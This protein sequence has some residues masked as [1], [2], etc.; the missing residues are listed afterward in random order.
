[1]SRTMRDVFYFR[2]KKVFLMKNIFGTLH[3]STAM[4][5]SSSVMKITDFMKNHDFH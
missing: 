5:E 3:Y 4:S 1:M 2:K